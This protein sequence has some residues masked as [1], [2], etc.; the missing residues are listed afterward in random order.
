MEKHG[1]GHLLRLAMR[2]EDSRVRLM[3]WR[4]LAEYAY[5]KPTQ[6]IAGDVEWGSMVVFTNKGE[7][8]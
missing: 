1:R 4:L 3:A 7:D 8:H 5:G 2:D 6:P